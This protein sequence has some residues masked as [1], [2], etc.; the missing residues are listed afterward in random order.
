M[1]DQR[2]GYNVSV[3]Y[4]ADFHRR[5]APDWLDFCIRAQG[6]DSP[7]TG[8]S[9]RYADLGCGQGFHLCLL[10]A[11]N[12]QAEFVGIDFDSSHV[13]HGKELAAAGGLTNVSFVQADFLE[14]AA[15]WPKELG[16]FDYIMLQGVLSWISAEI[17]AAVFRCVDKAS[18]P[19]TVAVLGYNCPPGWL[20]SVPF[21]HI[22]NQ[23]SK[24][25]DAN[26]ALSQTIG[27]FRRLRGVKSQ[28]FEQ[29]PHFKTHLE[30]LASQSPSYLAHE[31]LPDHWAP[32]WHSDVA[33]QMRKSDFTYLGSA[34]VAEAL[35]PDAL[36]PEL[37]AIIKEQTDESLR[38]DVQD[39]VIMK[40][41]RRDIFCREPRPAKSSNLESSPIYLMSAPQ[42]SAP[43]HFRTTF[44]EMA[45]EYNV[46]A[47]ILAALA[48][49][50]KPFV[51]LM[52]LNNPARLATRSVLLSMLDAQM[53]TIGR[54]DRGSVENA[55]QFNAAVARGASSGKPY[56]YLAAADLGSGIAVP[57]LDLL[58]LDTWLTEDRGTDPEE[59][60][61]GVA[62]RL[63]SLGRQLQFRGSVIG[64]ERLQLHIAKLFPIFLD[65]L[66][67]WRRLGVLQ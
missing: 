50:P 52:A 19:G 12:P 20:S 1:T 37:A 65:Q 60:A 34:A 27:M 53:L 39:I 29:I 46:V 7:R 18:K 5:M 28:L 9:Y 2:H 48:D 30:T 55:A 43:V 14:L 6:F 24:S 17:R 44:G 51:E 32:L 66:A 36:P 57:E 3:G 59:I 67:Q 25:H 45:V 41:F 26:A 16:I 42:E 11:A 49:G 8:P 21:Q 31:F 64:D 62:Q 58:L 22:A 4:T 61:R 56:Q 13:T 35:L 23:F 40:Q 38:E 54:A 63:K 10:A 33:Q 15:S 47:D